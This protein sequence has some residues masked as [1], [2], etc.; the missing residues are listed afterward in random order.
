MSTKFYNNA[1]TVLL[2][3]LLTGGMLAVGSIWG[4]QGVIVAFVFAVVT[5]VV[6]YFFS[7]KIA[8]AT[9]RAQQVGPESE[10]YQIVAELARRGN[11]PMPR[12][13][14][15]PQAAP[16]AFATGRNPQNAA[17]C[18]TVGLLER[19]N[20]DEIAGVMGHELAHVKHRD[21]L[22]STVAATIGGAI[23]TLAYMSMWFGGGSSD[24]EEGG[25][26]PLA[27]LLLLI[28]G[29]IAA[30]VIQM[31]ISRSRE[32][33]ADTEG[34]RLSGD[35]MY[36]ASALEKLHLYSQQIP[37]Q[38]NPAYNSMF[39]VEPLNALGNV[40]NLFATHPS[41]EQRLMNLIGRETTG[42]YRY[43]A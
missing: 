35:P 26:N 20:R 31:A 33:N 4:Q 17:V 28:L 25:S 6:G 32:Y 30:G 21:I 2:L 12:V 29:P 19:L 1:K 38:T 8:L 9:M 11:L 27:G 37:I 23:T 3:G 34:A 41:L 22:I 39:I 15:S 14:V 42:M 10:L 5:N 7:D 16:N 36:L 24:D 18:A 13:Y 43:A 40:G